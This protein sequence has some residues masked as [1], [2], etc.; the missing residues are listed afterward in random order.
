MNK[1]ERWKIESPNGWFVQTPE[2]I[3]IIKSTQTHHV[4]HKDQQTIITGTKTITVSHLFLPSI[5]VSSL[6]VSCHPSWDL[7]GGKCTRK[8][9]AALQL[10]YVTA[11]IVVF[12]RSLTSYKLLVSGN[13]HSYLFLPTRV[14]TTGA[15]IISI[16]PYEGGGRWGWIGWFLLRQGANALNSPCIMYSSVLELTRDWCTRQKMIH[17]GGFFRARES[18]RIRWYKFAV[19]FTRKSIIVIILQC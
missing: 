16:I 1:L 13:E 6:T 14:D 7:S 3:W 10:H 8:R 11:G 17:L 5:F 19:E 2:I 15:I 12:G 9:Y 18:V 4:S